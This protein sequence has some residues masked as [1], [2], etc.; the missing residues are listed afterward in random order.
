MKRL[1]S[2]DA[3]D[4]REAIKRS[5]E[6]KAAVVKADELKSG[7]HAMLNLGHTFESEYTKY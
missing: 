2:G 3:G 5:C 6:N 1:L 7:V 4:L